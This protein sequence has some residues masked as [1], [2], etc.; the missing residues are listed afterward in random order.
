LETLSQ[1]IPT[2]AFWQNG[3]DHLEDNVI[4][5]YQTLVDGGIVHLSAESI[6]NK[7]NEIWLD[8]DGW[9][10]KSDIQNIRK[11]FCKLYAKTSNN[12]VSELKKILLS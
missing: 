3:L 11:Q 2:L 7:V 8:V 9:W 4:P 6:A 12:P 5:H 10:G 1:N